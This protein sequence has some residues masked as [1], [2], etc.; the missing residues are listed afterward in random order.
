VRA[1]TNHSVKADGV[2]V[3]T[4]PTV[5]LFITRY[6][7]FS[8]SPASALSACPCPVKFRGIAMNTIK[9][10]SSGAFLLTAFVALTGSAEPNHD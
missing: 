6:C 10:L 1:A 3:L 5:S 7:D 4:P 2:P 8:D 9:R